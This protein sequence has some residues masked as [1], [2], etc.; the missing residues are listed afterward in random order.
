MKHFDSPLIKRVLL[1]RDEILVKADS[2]SHVATRLDSLFL[3][4]SPSANRAYQYFRPTRQKVPWT[5]VVWCPYI[6]PKHVFTRWLCVQGRLATRD[7]LP[8]LLEKGCILCD[9]DI[10]SLDHLFFECVFSKCLWGRVCALLKMSYSITTIRSALKVVQED[11]PGH[12]QDYKGQIAC[13][14]GYYLFHLVHWEHQDL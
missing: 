6:L 3:N 11:L 2:P 12:F 4:A 5:S 8:F 14:L 9:S 7:R 13:F 10:D 1:I